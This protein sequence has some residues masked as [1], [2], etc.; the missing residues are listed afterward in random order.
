MVEIQTVFGT[1]QAISE[2]SARSIIEDFAR[3]GPVYVRGPARLHTETQKPKWR[4]KQA[5]QLA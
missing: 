1:V 5:W 3:Y 2:R 4:G